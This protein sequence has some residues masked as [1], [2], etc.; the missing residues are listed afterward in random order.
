MDTKSEIDHVSLMQWQMYQA[1]CVLHALLEAPNESPSKYKAAE[2][3]LKMATAVA[4]DPTQEG[5]DRAV[6]ILL[7]ETAAFEAEMQPLK[8]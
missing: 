6:R 8:H 1:C 5:F 7:V 3:L 2:T 4:D